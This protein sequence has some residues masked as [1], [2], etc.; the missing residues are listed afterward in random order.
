M[1]WVISL[2]L[3]AVAAYFVI[4]ALNSKNQYNIKNQAI[5]GEIDA[6]ESAQL[7]SDTTS[8]DAFQNA[9]GAPAGAGSGSGTAGSAGSGS[10]SGTSASSASSA[11]GS[12]SSAS[13]STD[14]AS[15]AGV[16]AM[17]ATAAAATAAAAIANA[18]EHNLK[19]VAG[20]SVGEIQEMFKI[21]NL[22]DSDAGRLAIEKDQF[23]ALKS[24]TSKLGANELTAVADKLRWMLR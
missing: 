23:A 2:I 13:A 22:R 6:A 21:L 8:G 14:G 4:S 24:G 17:G 20:N 3:L 19:G 12:D 18:R 10:G 9:G 16:A 7:S 11:S 1:S 5:D 15:V